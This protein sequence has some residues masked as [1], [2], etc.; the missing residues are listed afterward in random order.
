MLPNPSSSTAA[1]ASPSPAPSILPPAQ[2][3]ETSNGTAPFLTN[4]TGERVYPFSLG[5]LLALQAAAEE[6]PETFEE[7]EWDLEPTDDPLIFRTLGG[8]R[9]PLY[10]TDDTGRPLTQEEVEAAL[11]AAQTE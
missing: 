1:S 7:G 2:E 11:G 3:S 10:L 4:S 8:N 9:I 5:T 6:D